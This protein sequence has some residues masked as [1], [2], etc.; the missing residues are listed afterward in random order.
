MAAARVSGVAASGYDGTP[1][2]KRVAPHAQKLT[3]RVRVQGTTAPCEDAC[4]LAQVLAWVAARRADVT[5]RLQWRSE[6]QGL[7]DDV[8]S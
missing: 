5:Q 3:D 1:A 2:H 6:I 8:I 7:M 4:E